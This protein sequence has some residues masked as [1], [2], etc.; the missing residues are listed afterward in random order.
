MTV[1]YEKER[2]MLIDTARTMEKMGL[3]KL[4]GGNVSMRMPCGNVLVTP[5]AMGYE[6]MVPE[7]IV[8]I[9]MQGNTV[10]GFRRPTSDWKAILYILREMPEMNV[11]LHTHQPAAI[12]LS[13]VADELPVISTTMVD[14]IQHT[15]RV[16]PFTISSDEGMGI[17]TVEHAGRALA[18]ILKHHGVIAYGRNMDQAL[19]A[20]VYLEES[21]EVYLKALA[22][23]RPI[24]VLTEEQIAAEDAPRGYYG[25]P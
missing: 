3:V 2:Q 6:N 10:E 16:A 14:E 12:A 21:C 20:V 15:V 11:V 8:L 17:A 5:S 13:L 18:V 1:L 25:Q 19:A 7:D 23:G 22:V 24:P 9:D 4:S